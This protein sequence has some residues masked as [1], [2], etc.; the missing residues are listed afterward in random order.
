METNKG[1]LIRWFDNK[2]FGFI[3]P[4]QGKGDIFIHISALKGM[5]RKPVVGDVIHYQIRVENSGKTRAVNARIEGVSP[6][7]TLAPIKERRTKSNSSS[8]AK[9]NSYRQPKTASKPRKNFS[10]IIFLIILGVAV[11]IYGQVA[12]D[13]F[14]IDLVNTPAVEIQPVEQF[15]CQGKTRCSEMTS[16][17]EAMFYLRNC[18]GT[19]MD[20]NHDGVPCEQQWCGGF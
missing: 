2:G 9:I 19:K 5:S 4:E 13:K 14:F 18:P 1:K 8:T 6:A 17:E 15:Q 7:L 16:C 11:F 3:K 20:G 10:I 12:K